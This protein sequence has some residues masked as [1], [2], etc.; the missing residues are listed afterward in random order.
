[1]LY[2]VI[3]YN[4]RDNFIDEKGKLSITRILER[5]QIMMKEEYSNRDKEFLE[6]EGRSY[7]FV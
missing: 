3:T 1:M 6:R 5:F 7:N 2:E 4:F